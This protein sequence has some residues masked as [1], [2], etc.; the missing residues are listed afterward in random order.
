MASICARIL[1][2]FI[3]SGWARADDESGDC[4]RALSALAAICSRTTNTFFPCCGGDELDIDDR[5]ARST[6]FAICSRILGIFFVCFCDADVSLAAETTAA[7]CCRMFGTFVRTGEMRLL[8]FVGVPRLPA[9]A[10][11]AWS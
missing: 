9:P 11:L 8:V 5:A 3:F 6:L 2:T 1:M 4:D 10:R 7:N